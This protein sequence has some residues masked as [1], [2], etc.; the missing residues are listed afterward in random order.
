MLSKD[1]EQTIALAHQHAEENQHQYMTTEHLLLA[2]LD[3]MA[4]QK[5]LLAC[6][7][8]INTLRDDLI[9]I[10]QREVPKIPQGKDQ[11]V[12]TSLAFQRVIQRA[13]FQGQA[14]G[15]QEIDG[16]HLLVAIFDESESFA[17]Y[18]LTRQN[19]LKLDILNY[20]AHKITKPSLN[21]EFTDDFND[22]DDEDLE[23]TPSALA[24]FTSNLNVRALDGNFDPLIGREAELNRLI[25]VLCRRNKNNPLL[26]GEAGV[27]KTAIAHAL[28]GKIVSKQITDE[29][30]NCVVHQLDLG[31]LIAG[32]KYRG[33]FEKR[34]KMLSDE[35]IMQPHIILFVDEIHTIIGAGSSSGGTLDASNL[36]KPLLTQG[37]VR[38]IGATTYKEYRTIFEKD[39]ALSRRFQTIDIKEPSI[40]ETI[41]ILK[42]LKAQ[43]E[44]YHKLKYTD[45][46][47]VS[48]VQLS[49]KFINDRY[50]PDKAFDVIDEAGA[51]QKIQLKSKRKKQITKQDIEI[52]VAQMAK[53]PLASLSESDIES[54][55][56]L[57][58]QLKTQIFG[59][60]QAIDMVV[61]TIKMSKAGL[62]EPH[63]TIAAFL[64]S[65]ATGVGKTELSVQLA[66]TLK[67][68]FIR[69]DMSEYMEK[70]S[71][72]RLIGAPPG[73]V[74]FDQAGLLSG[75]VLKTPYA[76][77][78][79][80]EIEKAH[81]DIL[82][83]LLQVMDNASL[84]D[85]NGRNVDFRNIILIMT[86]NSGAQSFQK[87]KIGFSDKNNPESLYN[88]QIII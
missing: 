77:I 87:N 48:A 84:T 26:I 44:E 25:Q 29:L 27:G 22:E 31:A 55:S 58:H 42:G 63:K 54:L 88:N 65:G 2:L 51:Y 78:L 85:A 17:H 6:G 82:N 35:L 30:A 24:L 8:D 60:N 81:P 76:L 70:H 19:I 49:A 86:T 41:L 39:A 66:Q 56:A 7:A 75:A 28:A 57:D 38:M 43:F 37:A 16:T 59:Q 71:V 11:S 3:N 18:F 67:I 15:K 80:D 20:I 83:I 13:L 69:F 34:I 40:A 10:M 50:L 73:Y 33:D 52:I 5:V 12:Q 23:H 64:F 53:I 61:D 4:A 9:K 32:T 36:I 79:L 74:G 21:N 1:L 47:L 68:P 14:S 45:D 46:A 72:A 62:R